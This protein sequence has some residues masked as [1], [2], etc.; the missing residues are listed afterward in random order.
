MATGVIRWKHNRDPDTH[1]RNS[2]CGGQDVKAKKGRALSPYKP[3]FFEFICSLSCS[4]F[5]KEA[6]CMAKYAQDGSSLLRAT[7]E[8]FCKLFGARE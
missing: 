2:E 6:A 1:A 4:D 8:L 3:A 5:K 7:C